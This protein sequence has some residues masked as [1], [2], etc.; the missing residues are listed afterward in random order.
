MHISLKLLKGI[1]IPAQAYV[2]QLYEDEGVETL[3]YPPY[4]R[5]DSDTQA[6]AGSSLNLHSR[7]APAMT[8]R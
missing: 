6:W 3:P 8:F 5:H 1:R 2:Q 4:G 7:T